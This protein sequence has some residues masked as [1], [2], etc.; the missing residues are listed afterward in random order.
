MSLTMTE[1][2]LL[3]LCNDG[4]FLNSPV[5]GDTLC[6]CILLLGRVTAILL[7]PLFSRNFLVYRPSRRWSKLWIQINVH[8]VWFFVLCH[9]DMGGRYVGEPKSNRT[10]NL[11]HGL[12]VVVRCGTRSCRS[13]KTL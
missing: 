10:L 12:E 2:Q 5:T 9:H 7:L 11:A 3:R 13:T 6:G 8:I 4:P 1:Y